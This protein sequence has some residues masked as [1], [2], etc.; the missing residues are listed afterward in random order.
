VK[1]RQ[2]GNFNSDMYVVG[3]NGWEKGV[4]L[5]CLFSMSKIGL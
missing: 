5:E 1:W 4:Y 2:V 3:G